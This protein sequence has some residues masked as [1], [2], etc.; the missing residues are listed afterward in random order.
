MSTSTTTSTPLSLFNTS[1]M[2]SILSQEMT[3]TSFYSVPISNI[4][5]LPQKNKNCF[6]KVYHSIV[7]MGILICVSLLLYMV[8]HVNFHMKISGELQSNFGNLNISLQSEGVF[9]LTSKVNSSIKT[10][11]TQLWEQLYVDNMLS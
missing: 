1:A 9:N 2:P 4:P 11:P 6:S 8:I 10:A 3:D 5:E 7:L